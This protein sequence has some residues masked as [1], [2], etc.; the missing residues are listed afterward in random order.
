[1]RKSIPILLIAF[2]ISIFSY[3]QNLT[4]TNSDGW[5][6]SAYVTWLPVSNA[7]SYNVYFSGEG[8]TSQK[9]D[10]PLIRSYGSYYRADIPGLKAGNYTIKVAPVISGSEGQASETATLSVQALDR[11]GFSFN[12]G[13]TPGAYRSDGTP[14]SGAVILYITENTKNTVSLDVVGANS[15]PCVGLQE[16]LDGYKKGNDTRPLIIRM[17][18]QITDPTNLLNGD[19][20]IE[21]KKNA[22]SYITLEGVGEDAV[23]DGWGIRIKNA[24][25]I[26]IR[27]IATMNCNSGEGDNIGLQQNNEYVWIHHCDFFYGDAGGDGD[28][29]KGD[30]ALDCKKSTYVT[31]SY[32]HFWD[33]GKANLLGLSEGTTEGLYITYHHNWYD[34]SDSRH[35]RV[36]FYS[37][38]VYNNYYDGIS[39]YGVGS[40]EGSSLLV[41]GNYFRNCRYPILTSM[42]GSDIFNESTGSNDYDRATFSS[43]DGGSIK[44]VNNYMV[45]QQRFVPYGD[46]N[47]PNST[48]DFDAYVVSSPTDQMPSSVQSAR[49]GNTHNNF[50]TSAAMYGYSV[51]TPE[52]A[53]NTIMQY[54]GRMNGGDFSWTFNNSVDDASSS[55]NAAL[56]SALFNYQ[57]NL[58]SVQG[59]G[60]VII[61]PGGDYDLVVTV[62][63]SGQVSG[64]GTYDEGATAT[65]TATPANG[66]SFSNWS[67]DATGSEASVD[68]LMNSN[69]AV[70]AIF[71]ED[72]NG[73][74][75]DPGDFDHNFTISSLNSSF[76]DI[77][78]NL[79]TSKGTVN[80]GGLTLTQ[81]LKI[82]SSTSISFRTSQESTLTLV[83][84]NDFNGEFKIDGISYSASSGIISANINAGNHTLTKDD[85][86][87]L[88]FM[89]VN[90]EGN[91][92]DLNYTLTTTVNG[93]GF[94]TPDGGTYATGETVSI[95]ATPESGWQ[96]DGW[97]EDLIGNPVTVLMDNDKSITANFSLIP[98]GNTITI[99]ENTEG[100]CNVQGTVDN[101]NSGFTG[102]GFANTFNETGVAI[103]YTISAS[104]GSATLL[105]R[106]ANG[107]SDRPARILV[108]GNQQG[109]SLNFPST[110]SWISWTNV[111]REITLSTGVNYITLEATNTGGL[112]NVDYVEITAS[113]V[114]S[115]SCSGQY[116]ARNETD[117]ELITV[118]SASDRLDVSDIQIYPNPVLHTL[119]LSSLKEI[120]KVEIYSLTGILAKSIDNGFNEI[121]V[122]NLQSGHYI[123]RVYTN[124][125]I[126]MQRIVKQ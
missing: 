69:K 55:V 47:Y 113:G 108:N 73:G 104:G 84:N 112:A 54:A 21:N 24:V 96:F 67:G 8:V 44:A 87:N 59:E 11:T 91:E 9:I 121:E 94:V 118:L 42:Q 89:S 126:G 66:W 123:L 88:Y 82:E 74:E 75:V 27:N 103:N 92:P 15:N 48:V 122:G 70:T 7:D 125:G 49:G 5:L 33:T 39:K 17:V 57:T 101:N 58:V 64:A 19:I 35:P 81:C 115:T 13:R 78:G 119:N 109:T 71:T 23:A 61:N 98:T 50:N 111:S 53:R 106:Y 83:F 62:S 97:S 95:S 28:Q 22:S 12:N 38:H 34:H 32:N 43:E 99:Q 63:G 76:Y 46:S 30:G 117:Q 85:V 80:Y 86:T 90:Y 4:I 102:S 3:A 114:S 26:E 2:L 16:I 60:G 20:V 6:E 18:G 65:L 36:R 93:Q 79:S 120:R 110:G 25:N 56:K 72:E 124:E 105:I 116:N 68:V 77:S 45:G 10:D 14:K 37:A 29:A 40:T 52:A 100:F 107:A 41:E 51:Q 31:F 1:M